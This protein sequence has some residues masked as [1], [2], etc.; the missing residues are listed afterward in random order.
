MGTWLAL[1]VQP[2]SASEWLV[3]GICLALVGVVRNGSFGFCLVV[4]SGLICGLQR[5]GSL[6]LEQKPL[7]DLVGQEVLL[8]GRI[9]EDPTYDINGDL[10]LRLKQVSIG[11]DTLSGDVWVSTGEKLDIKRSDNIEIEG[12]LSKG[13]GVITASVYRAHVVSVERAD[14]ADVARDVRDEFAQGIR[15]SIQEPQASLGAGFLLGQKS[16]LPEKLDIELRLLGLTHVVVASG[17]NLTILI[18]F[19][20]RLF[21]RISRFSALALSGGLVYGFTQVTGWSPSMTRAGLVA[22]LSLLAWYYGRKFHPFVLL[23]F[24]AGLT[25]M[26]NPTYAWG[27]IGWLLSFTSF[28]G[29]IILAPLIQSFFWGSKKPNFA[30]QIVVE[31]MSAQVLTL[32]IIMYVFGQYSPL[33]L[34]ANL[35]VLPLI[36]LVMLLTFLAGIVGIFASSLAGIIGWPAESLMRY[37]TFV[38]DRLSELPAASS[39]VAVSITGVII[40]YL[41]LITAIVFLFRRTRLSFRDYNVIE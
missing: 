10:R 14:Y 36:P 27:D 25:V 15:A 17:Y 32:P 19:A 5:G 4:T 28:V 34:L 39:E 22:T 7:Q 26:V 20:R 38:I 8:S 16:A 13:F 9:S 21:N 6:L 29:V 35:L 31:T 33:A 40:M 37:M 1:R 11:G 23:S 24:S 3:I 12:Q 18:R 41:S 2:F 30:K